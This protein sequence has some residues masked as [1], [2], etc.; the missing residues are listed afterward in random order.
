MT[1]NYH[2]VQHDLI[3][4][5]SSRQLQLHQPATS[6]QRSTELPALRLPAAACGAHCDGLRC[7][8]A[9]RG[10]ARAVGMMYARRADG[11]AWGR[12]DAHSRNGG[13]RAQRQG[14]VRT[15][16]AAEAVMTACKGLGMD[17]PVVEDACG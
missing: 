16:G 14:Q 17:A 7:L 4:G 11:R 5:Y 12:P 3:S 8:C 9:T 1:G 15:R 13:E 2:T 10:S 6:A